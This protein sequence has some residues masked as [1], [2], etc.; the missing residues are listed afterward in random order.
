M[1][2]HVKMDLHQMYEAEAQ[3]YITVKESQKNCLL[4]LVYY[5]SQNPMFYPP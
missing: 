3:E 4:S 5:Q 1:I 2:V